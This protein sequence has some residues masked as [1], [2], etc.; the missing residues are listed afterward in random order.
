MFRDILI[1]YDGSPHAERALSE[2]ID[3]AQCSH[4]RL[5]ILTAVT[6][7]P[8]WTYAGPSVCAAAALCAELEEES[9]KT[10]CRAVDRVPDDLPVTKILSHEPIVKALMKEIKRGRHDLVV[11]GSRGFGAIK[12]TLLGSV[13]QHVLHHSPVPVLIV[14]AEPEVEEKAESAPA[15][16]V[17]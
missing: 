15:E 7:P 10:L 3:L 1:S 14:H 17:A 2:A 12:G 5:T 9:A 8:A 13:S 4:A 6:K 11:M 16:A